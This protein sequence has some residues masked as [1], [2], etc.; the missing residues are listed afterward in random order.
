MI[1]YYITRGMYKI[2]LYEEKLFGRYRTNRELTTILEYIKICRFMGKTP[3]KEKDFYR[4]Y[5]DTLTTSK[6][7]NSHL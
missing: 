2:P 4:E 6:L 5:K 1:Y 7:V 3:Q